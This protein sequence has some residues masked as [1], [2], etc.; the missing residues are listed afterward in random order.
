MC[1]LISI[2]SW[3][4]WL[5]N[6]ITVISYNGVGFLN[7][8]LYSRRNKRKRNYLG[9]QIGKQKRILRLNWIKH[10]VF[11]ST[12]MCVRKTHSWK[13]DIFTL[14]SQRYILR[15]FNLIIW[16]AQWHG[17]SLVLQHNSI[18]D[19]KSFLDKP[20]TILK[21]NVSMVSSNFILGR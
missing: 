4:V 7:I 11:I 20:K 19:I 21:R 9:N 15:T 14:K 8:Q 1:R 13:C 6:D 10:S 12:A 18:F 17:L 5:L 2:D 3:F 16:P